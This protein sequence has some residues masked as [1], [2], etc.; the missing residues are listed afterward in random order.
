MPH[1]AWLLLIASISFAQAP[2]ERSA[3]Y[4][5]DCDRECLIALTRGHMEA[6]AKREPSRAQFATH[7]RFTENNVELT[8]GR[9]GLWRTITAVAATGL[10]AADPSTGQAAW[11]GTVE[12]NGNPVYYGMRLKVEARKISEVETIVVRRTGL[13]LP[14]GDVKKLVHDPSFAEVMPPEQRRPR[15]RL[16][17][18]A[19]SYFSTVELNDGMVF[20][21][22]TDDCAR[23]EN[24]IVTTRAGAGSSG[25]IAQGCEDQ[26]KLGIYRINK[27]I[28]ERRYPLIDEERGVVVATGFFDHANTF[29]TYKTTDGKERKTLL[30]WPNSISLVEAFKI[31]D[32]RIYRIEAVFTYVPYFM[33]SPFADVPP[34]KASKVATAT[35]AS[36]CDRACLIQHADRYVEALVKRDPS[37]LPWATTVRFTENSVPMM[38]GDGTWGSIRGQATKALS[39]ADPTT[40]NV[41][42]LG[43][44]NDHDLPAFY[45][46]RLRVHGGRITEVD[47]V[48]ARKGNPGPFG[49][50][51]RFEVDAALDEVLS[52]ERLSR[53]RLQSIVERAEPSTQRRENGVQLTRTPDVPERVRARRF[54]LIDPERGIVVS[55]GFA[56]FPADGKRPQADP[57][58]SARE[59]FEIFKVR[60][61]AIE[62]IEA[63]SIFQAYGMPSPWP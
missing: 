29:D 19:D 23:I 63:L 59:T 51:A 30:K 55:Q 50:P 25:D 54:P 17:A 14:F 31:R 40:G 44:V 60:N 5:I 7:V 53:S 39:A 57:Y 33:H 43:R 36:E 6:L 28:R 52:G 42:W 15:E 62:R 3:I 58:P 8:A 27:R 26:F 4:A 48:V 22:F 2:G 49:D 35:K 46:M 56:D 41:V 13:P 20:A 24:G 12:E 11:I 45:A 34:I 18:V 16:L 9:D 1:A 10:E 32:G 21:P 47:T 37:G 61:G 38:I